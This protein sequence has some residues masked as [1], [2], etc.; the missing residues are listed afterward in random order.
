M[1]NTKQTKHTPGPWRSLGPTIVNGPIGI[2]KDTYIG[3]I[4]CTFDVATAHRASKGTA[5]G[6][7][8]ESEANAHLIA[9]APDLLDVVQLIIK[10]WEK[11]TEGV[12]VGEL[13]ARLSQYSVEAR[14]AIAKA[15]GG[16]AK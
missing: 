16:G 13:I 2:V 10:E 11:P 14:A 5:F 15:T 3:T 9:A 7:L 1:S 4:E 12:Q 6:G 8:D